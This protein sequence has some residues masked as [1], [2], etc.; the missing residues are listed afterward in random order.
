MIRASERTCRYGTVSIVGLGYIGLPTAAMFAA[1][2]LN[3]IGVDIDPRAVDAVNSGRAHIEEGMLDEL[4]ERCVGAGKLTAVLTPAEADAFIIAVPTPVG[5][6]E[7]HSPDI[8]F[9]MAAAR[10]IAPFL[11]R[12]TLIILESTSPV[13]T[14]EK[15]AALLA[16]LREDLTFAGQSD[17]PDVLLAYC[18][19]RIIPGRMLEELV[20]NERIIGGLDS[21]SS[22]AAAELYSLFVKGDLHLSSARVAEMVKLAE[23]SFRDVNIAFAN[24][25][26]MLCDQFGIDA[27]D[28]IELAN[29]HPR[30]NILKPGS[31]V[32]G[33]CIAVDPWFIVAG[34]PKLSR[35]I[36]TAREV[37]DAK[38]GFVI[39]KVH[40]A[41]D[42]A[43]AGIKVA[44]FGLSYKPDVDD[45]RESP[46][47]EI[48]RELTRVLGD[49]VVCTDPFAER[50]RHQDASAL[51]VVSI[52]EAVRTAG[53]A[54]VLVPHRAFNDIDFGVQFKIVV[55]PVGLMKGRA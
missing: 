3:V 18:P 7:N 30:V 25:L 1:S 43:G 26:S 27:F 12:G 42:A 41:V 32:G 31:G 23:N 24:E 19:E 17:R 37:N 10:S 33:H 22:E 46:A 2:G 48:A 34:S 21:H 9:V 49:A 53:I 4:V 8:S 5:H 16:S 50:L 51:N 36:R 14:T 15:M 40:E 52:E 20:E 11:K 44:C 54:V 47:L 45:F 55:D 39:A 28:V 35:L 6:D 29:R 38:P 13:G